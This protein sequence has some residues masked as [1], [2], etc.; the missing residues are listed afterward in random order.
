[1]QTAYIY[2][3]NCPD[4]GEPRY[5]GKTVHPSN[6]LRSH[7]G[8][9]SSCY[10]R[11]WIQSLKAQGKRPKMEILESYP[12]DSP[13]WQEAE[14]FYIIYLRFLGF[15]LTNLSDGGDAGFSPNADVRARMSEGQKRS[16]KTLAHLRHQAS[17]LKGIPRKGSVK[18]SISEATKG[19][20][21]SPETCVLLSKA[22]TGFKHTEETKRI[23]GEHSRARV[24]RPET[25]A[26]IVAANTG[27]KRTPEQ[28]ER[29]RIAITGRKLSPEHIAK[30]S[31]A[32]TAQWA[33][34]RQLSESNAT[35]KK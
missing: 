22:R 27:K 15:R 2:T 30:M 28:I 13:D 31:I 5:V 8:L 34:R 10:C 32:A 3:L 18:R 14:R 4:T 16:E 12:Q 33:K 6:R 20:V 21:R 1:M 23:I 26:K 25:T 17:L 35:P 7:L 11:N 9:H 24:R 19:K 29:V